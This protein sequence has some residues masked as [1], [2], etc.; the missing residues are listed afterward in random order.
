VR[1]WTIHPRYLDARGL[2]ALW[3]EGL[4]AQAVLRGLTRGYARHPQLTRFRQARAP[5]GC[6]R[7]YLFA[8]LE[9]AQR[10]GYRFDRRKVGRPGRGERIS[11]TT[12]QL[13]YEWRHLEAKLKLRDRAW[14]S[15][16]RR[17]A[18]PDAHPLFRVVPGAVEPWEVGRTRRPIR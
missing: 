18:Q 5:L 14:L 17:V 11:V 9:E 16:L 3:R 1:L 4:L 13:R 2:V 12:G 6:L 10:R 7:R 8:V 15:S